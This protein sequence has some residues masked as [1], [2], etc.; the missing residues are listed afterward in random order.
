MQDK[1]HEFWNSAWLKSCL[2]DLWLRDLPSMEEQQSL[3]WQSG[4]LNDVISAKV[5]S[6]EDTWNSGSTEQLPILKLAPVS[7]IIPFPATPQQWHW[8]GQTNHCSC[9]RLPVLLCFFSSIYVS[10]TASDS[11]TPSGLPLPSSLV[12]SFKSQSSVPPLG[13]LPDSLSSSCSLQGPQQL[14]YLYNWPMAL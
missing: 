5:F 10:T 7:L 8:L 14:L 11:R 9:P 4:G 2:C 3:R 1:E 6:S 12:L 13:S